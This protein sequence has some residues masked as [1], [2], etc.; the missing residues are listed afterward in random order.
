VTLSEDGAELKLIT[1]SARE[2]E[3]IG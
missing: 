2:P 1:R 3:L